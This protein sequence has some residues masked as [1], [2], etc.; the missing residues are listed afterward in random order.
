MSVSTV[1][2]APPDA[3]ISRRAPAKRRRWKRRLYRLMLILTVGSAIGFLTATI[4]RAR[5]EY[6]ARAGRDSAR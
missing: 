3:G 4:E 1:A 2:S 6:M 5:E